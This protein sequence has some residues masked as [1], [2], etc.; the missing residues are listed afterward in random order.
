M[1]PGVL[2]YPE[3]RVLE[4]VLLRRPP[5]LEPAKRRRVEVGSAEV[6][7]LVAGLACPFDRLPEEQIVRPQRPMPWIRRAVLVDNAAV[8]GE[9]DGGRHRV[10]TYVDEQDA[11]ETTLD[12][13]R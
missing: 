13:L 2:R 1:A 9:E 11:P 12:H 3:E 8:P 7:A 5:E 6:Q 4:W 10:G